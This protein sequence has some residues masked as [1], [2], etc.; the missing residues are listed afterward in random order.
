MLVK[1][2]AMRKPKKSNGF[3]L[4]ELLVVIAI[5]AI[6]AS[7]LLPALSKAKAKAQSISCLNNTKQLA[8]ASTLYAGDNDDKWPANGQAD[9]NLN[10][11]NPAPNYVPRVWAEG[12]EGSNLTDEDSARGMVSDRVSLIARYM[13]TK[14]SFRC[15]GDKQLIRSGK[16]TFLRP[17]DYGMNIF[18]AWTQD[19]Y[20]GATYHSEPN[21]QFRNFKRTGEVTRPADLFLFGEIHPFSI[22]QPPFGVHPQKGNE[23]PHVFHYP[24]NLHGQISNFSFADG[25]AESHHWTSARMNSPLRNGK[26]VPET[27][28]AFWHGS[29]DQ[30]H[31]NSAEVKPDLI[32]LGLHA[33]EHR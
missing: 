9:Q 1:N 21:N 27:D 23:T 29:H 18:I 19:S 30:A 16:K 13:K 28:D 2:S 3:T 10:L 4:I 24:G 15:P 7:M 33:A 14:D 32:W 5:I 11:A 26:S 31:P 8:L 22:C 6:L 25:H 20:T 12:R 17:K